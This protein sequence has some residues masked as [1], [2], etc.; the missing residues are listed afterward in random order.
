[1]WY[2]FE[3]IAE[4]DKN[5]GI[6]IVEHMIVNL[7]GSIEFIFLDESTVEIER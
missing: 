4:F 2:K 1:L 5:I 7:D 3:L 6:S